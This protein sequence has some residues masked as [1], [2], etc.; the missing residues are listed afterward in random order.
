M[1]LPLDIA[2]GQETNATRALPATVQQGETFE[3]TIAFTASADQ[4]GS[5]AVRDTGPD[6]WNATVNVAWCNDTADSVDAVGNRASITWVGPYSQGTN[7]TAMYKVTVPC[8]ASLISHSFN[9]SEYECFCSYCIGEEERIREN[10]TGD[11]EVQVIPPAILSSAA[12]ISF[13]AAFGGQ[14]PQNQTLQLW[15]STPCMLNWNLTDDA[16][17]NGADWLSASPTNG[18]CTDVPN[19]TTLSVNTSGMDAGNYTA[20]ISIEAPEARNSPQII[21]VGLYIRETGTLQGTVNFEGRDDAPNDKWIEPFVV[22]LF[23]AGDLSQP[24]RTEVATTN[25][26]GVFNITE[27]VAG[28][29]DIGIKNWTCLSKLVTNVTVGFNETTVVDFGTTR[30]G[31]ANNDDYINPSDF[32]IISFAWLSYPGQPNWNAAVDFNR[33]NYINPSDFSVLS[34]SWLQ[35]GDLYGV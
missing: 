13:Y 7:F 12:S 1:V 22:K 23:R 29:Y 27:V 4:F 34:Y 32:A 8:N 31:D 17:Y 9:L 10:I 3:V 6:G 35:W 24:I 25:N 5:I 20:N 15:S 16:D 18:S 19:S 2:S 11:Y 33:D 14:N 26:T 21:P 28:I 30:E